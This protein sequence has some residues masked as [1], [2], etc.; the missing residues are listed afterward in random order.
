MYR[1]PQ[2]ALACL[3]VTPAAKV[4]AAAE[5]IE[6]LP[7]REQRRSRRGELE[8]EWKLVEPRA[9]LA[10]ERIRLVVRAG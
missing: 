5:A 4:E 2:R 10:D 1:R 3:G 8:R 7:R 6:E 9:K